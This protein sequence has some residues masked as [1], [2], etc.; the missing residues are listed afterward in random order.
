MSDELGVWSAFF[1]L[2]LAAVLLLPLIY[3]ATRWYARSRL[4]QGRGRR[5]KVVDGLMLG[6]RKA[7]YV[8]RVGA[9]HYL[10]GVTDGEIRLLSRLPADEWTTAGTGEGEAGKAAERALRRRGRGESS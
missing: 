8:L 5:L 3:A 9:R 4:V 10:V 1:R 7:V 6:P 2:A